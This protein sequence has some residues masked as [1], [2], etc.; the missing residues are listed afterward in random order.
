M[1]TGWLVD[2]SVDYDWNVKSRTSSALITVGREGSGTRTWSVVYV[3]IKRTN[4]WPP[5]QLR[6]S[7]DRSNM[8][9]TYHSKRVDL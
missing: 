9:P 4:I 6:V 8:I 3:E 2:E 1:V 5:N 7:I